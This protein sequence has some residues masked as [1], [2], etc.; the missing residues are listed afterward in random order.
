MIPQDARVVASRCRLGYNTG[1][2][3]WHPVSSVVSYQI[4]TQVE[5]KGAMATATITLEGPIVLLPLEEYE[6]LMERLESLE[7]LLDEELLT[8]SVLLHELQEARAD[9]KAGKGG[10]YR[11]LRKKLLA[12]DETDT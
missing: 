12:R 3:E 8:S 5:R 4:P 6:S 1:V 2:Q 10:H 7:D 9:Y 11:E